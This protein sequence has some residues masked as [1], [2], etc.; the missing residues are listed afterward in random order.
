MSLHQD[1]APV[2]WAARRFPVLAALAPVMTS[3][4]GEITYPGDPMCL[5]AAL[6]VTVDNGLRSARQ[7]AGVGSPFSDLCPD[8]G[9]PV[10]KAQ[11]LTAEHGLRAWDENDST[12]DHTVFDPR[13][14]DEQARA[15]LR[16]EL[17]RRR[18]RV[19]LVSTVSPGHRYALEMAAIAKEI[20]PDCLVVFGGRHIDETMRYLPAK[21]TLALEYSSTLRAMDDGRVG[22][23]VDLLVSGEGYFALDILMRAIA[24][25]MD[26]DRGRARVED[27]VGMLE[28]LG[29]AGE[30]I[31]GSSLICA[32]LPEAAHAFPVRG[33]K[34]DLADLPSPYVGF[35]VRSRFPIFPLSDGSPARTAHM[36]VSNACPYHCDFCSESAVLAGGLKRFGGSPADAA[37]E[38]I[39]EY[40][41]YGAEAVF[42]DDSIF[43]SGTFP[44]I[45]SFCE[46][47]R[48]ARAASGPAELPERCRKWI[49][50]EG[51]WERLR[52]LQ[53]GC[54]VTADLLTTL[55]KEQDVRDVLDLMREAGCTY[56]YM[57]IESMSADV[58]QHVHKNVRRIEDFP[59]KAKVRM[60]L[61]RIRDAGIPVGSS[62]LFGLEGE[63]M[64][65]IEETVAEVG[66]LID[67]GLLMLASPNIL[68]YHPATP[69]TRAHGMTERLD[70]HSPDVENRPP[71]TFFEE[72]FPG[73]VSL[74][75]SEE[76]VW[77]I[78]EATA[79]RWGSIRN[80]A[81]P[82]ARVPVAVTA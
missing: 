33:P 74:R 2:A 18:P 56:L 50:D 80:S 24:L 25:A 81:E 47:L 76:Q 28:L 68:T 32:V 71:Y 77:Y 63:T 61:E 62:V 65:S 29:D 45:R 55:H 30:R 41:S 52:N 58:M 54:Q 23:V 27:V 9:I 11:R 44:S 13:V 51:D 21:K 72:A 48:A 19:F 49:T 34:Y 10:T 1:P 53:F 38:R 70:Y 5:Y 75:L 60:A 36:I 16:A 4:E 43:W 78:H 40:V 17:T 14:W 59:W 3:V 20:V 39:C 35:A 79:K 6:C 8:W 22:P 37:L 26:L 31:P 73:V 67:D 57:G 15:D 12:P 42:F 46:A 64:D 82:D 7:G 69:I 66:M